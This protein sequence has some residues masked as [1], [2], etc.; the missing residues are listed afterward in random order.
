M[1]YLLTQGNHSV[2][3]KLFLAK[4]DEAIVAGAFILQSGKNMHYMFGAVDRHHASSRAGELVQWSVIESACEQGCVRY[5]L[6]GIDSDESSG[7]TAFKKKM[8]GKI[9]TL[10][11]SE[12]EVINRRGK[13]LLPMMQKK[14]GL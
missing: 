7:V 8:G 5:D 12:I 4:R 9:I 10:P 11:P 6:E 1:Q 13:L 14:L 3:G 2:S